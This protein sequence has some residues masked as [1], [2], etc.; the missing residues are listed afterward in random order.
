MNSRK[1]FMWVIFRALNF[2]KN[3]LNITSK[4]L[5]LIFSEAQFFSGT[6]RHF[7]MTNRYTFFASHHTTEMSIICNNNSLLSP[8][9]T[10]TQQSECLGFF[11]SLFIFFM[12]GIFSW[13]KKNDVRLQ[14][15]L[16]CEIK[17][18]EES[19]WVIL[20]Y[21]FPQFSKQNV[22]HL[23]QN[24]LTYMNVSTKVLFISISC[25]FLFSIFLL[26][27]SSNGICLCCTNIL[28]RGKT[29]FLLPSDFVAATFSI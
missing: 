21:F 2:S 10:S 15:A 29:F 18:G 23:P 22:S 4:K 9:F 14:N 11:F 13:K 8:P 1:F 12:C 16:P 5:T 17:V 3:T 28:R 6:A 24:S 7:F 20:N 19:L 25:L 27:L 26:S